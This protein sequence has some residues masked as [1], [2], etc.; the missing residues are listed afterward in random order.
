M[1]EDDGGLPA[2]TERLSPTRVQSNVAVS[3]LVAS[4]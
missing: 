2:M 1:R 3:P 4:V